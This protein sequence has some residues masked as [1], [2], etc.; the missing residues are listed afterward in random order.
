MYILFSN[1]DSD[2]LNTICL[3]MFKLAERNSEKVYI[4]WIYYI[5]CFYES[6]FFVSNFGT[7]LRLNSVDKIHLK[8]TVI[9]VK[10]AGSW[11]NYLCLAE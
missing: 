2:P 8:N 5:L 4:Y 7:I 11:N 9:Y 6:S 1:L 10:N 3:R